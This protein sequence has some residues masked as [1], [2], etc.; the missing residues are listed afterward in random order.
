MSNY[1][2]N[3]LFCV[4][5]DWRLADATLSILEGS[6][7]PLMRRLF[8]VR[9]QHPQLA[10]NILHRCGFVVS[11]Q[12]DDLAE[13]DP[14]LE[15]TAGFPTYTVVCTAADLPKMICNAVNPPAFVRI[16]PRRR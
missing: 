15:L 11:S 5:F 3:P 2:T 12:V 10:A 1:P 13:A 6:E 7:T 4:N 16:A 9:R 8:R 14:N